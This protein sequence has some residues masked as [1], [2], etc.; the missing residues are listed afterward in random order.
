MRGDPGRRAREMG[1][2][3]D[4]RDPGL[5]VR[6]RGD[7]L[8]ADV[9][10]GGR[11]R[12]H[13]VHGLP[14]PDQTD[15]GGGAGLVVGQAVQ[16]QHL[17]T[18]LLDRAD[19]LLVGAAR[20]RGPAGHLD[21]DE[22]RALAAD[23]QRARRPAGLGVEHRAGAARGSLDHRPR[24]GRGDLLIGGDQIHERPRRAAE[25]GERLEHERV[26]HQPGLHVGD[27]RAVSPIALDPERPLGHGAFREHGVAMPE[28]Q[29][30]GV[31]GARLARPH[32]GL[33]R[34]AAVG[35]DHLLA[36]DAAAHQ[37]VIDD[38]AGPGHALPVVRARI[39]VDELAQQLDHR[40]VL[41]IQP[42]EQLGLARAERHRSVLP[43]D[44]RA[45]PPLLG[46]GGPAH[47]ARLCR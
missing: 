45:A 35:L 28:Q 22:H 10:L 17:A 31:V 25:P 39:D 26:H 2:L 7:G 34:E 32:R 9:D 14:A 11:E 20:M 8:E 6:H 44:A 5:G 41:G 40:L 24:R 1:A 16:L 12:R 21:R 3:Q 43:I 15:V 23:D 19:P 37:V 47:G 27:A 30:M 4:R 46:G 29:D 38:L 36:R 13:G 42:A 33:H 18:E